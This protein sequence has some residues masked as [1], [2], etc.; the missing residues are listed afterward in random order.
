MNRRATFLENSVVSFP[1]W[2]VKRER[3]FV[4]F[5]HFVQYLR[6][7]CKSY[8]NWELVKKTF[9]SFNWSYKFSIYHLV[10]HKNIK[11]INSKS[12]LENTGPSMEEQMHAFLWLIWKG[13][14][15]KWRMESLDRETCIHLPP[16]PVSNKIPT[17]KIRELFF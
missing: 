15:I 9:L 1:L 11:I 16:T 10:C 2:T 8:L 5:A 13:A 3:F 12:R 14:S 7:I 17:P 6:I 4:L